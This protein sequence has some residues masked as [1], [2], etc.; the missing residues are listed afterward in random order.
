ML[1]PAWNL[2]LKQLLIPLVFPEEP[3]SIKIC[4]ILSENSKDLADN[5]TNLLNFTRLKP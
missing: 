4:S 2:H 1:D 3:P 5:D